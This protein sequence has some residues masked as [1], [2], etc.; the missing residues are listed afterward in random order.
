M[1]FFFPL[2][3]AL[4]AALLIASIVGVLAVAFFSLLPVVVMVGGGYLLFRAVSGGGHSHGLRTR[5]MS[6]RAHGPGRIA[7]PVEQGIFCPSC[8]QPVS[9]QWAT[10]PH[11]GYRK[12]LAPDL[13]QRRCAT[14]ST[15]L[16]KDWNACPY[17]STRIDA[18]LTAAAPGPGQFQHQTT[19]PVYAET[20]SSV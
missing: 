2:L 8:N 3:G 5:S 19:V 1:F 4:A 20:A 10:C 6:F 15:E 11:C 14:C 13:I 18:P 9:R 12:Y 7:A 16:Q 17:C